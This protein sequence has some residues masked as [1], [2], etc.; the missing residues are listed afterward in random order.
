MRELAADLFATLLYALLATLLTAAGALLE[1]TS[2]QY[3]GAG[4]SFVALWLAVVGALALYAG[5]YGIGY[6]KLLARVV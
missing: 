6:Q 3:L 5:V 4:E 2:L 1:Y